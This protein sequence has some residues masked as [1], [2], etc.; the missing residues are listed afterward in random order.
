[1]TVA[2]EYTTAASDILDARRTIQILAATCRGIA[3]SC[4]QESLQDQKP[5]NNIPHPNERL[6]D[7]VVFAIIQG[8]IG[9]MCR[10]KIWPNDFDSDG[11]IKRDRIPRGPPVISWANG[12]PFFTVY[13]GYYILG[14]HYLA[15][16]S[17]LLSASSTSIYPGCLAGLVI[18]SPSAIPAD[19]MLLSEQIQAFRTESW[20][21]INWEPKSDLERTQK[22]FTTYTKDHS[23]LS[24]IFFGEDSFGFAPP[25]REAASYNLHLDPAETA[26]VSPTRVAINVWNQTRLERYVNNMNVQFHFPIQQ[27]TLFFDE[28]LGHPMS[29]AQ[30]TLESPLKNLT[31][32]SESPKKKHPLTPV[33]PVCSKTSEATTT[34]KRPSNDKLDEDTPSKKRRQLKTHS[35]KMKQQQ[36]TQQKQQHQQHHLEQEQKQRQ[37][38]Q[39][40]QQQQQEQK[41]QPPAGH[42]SRTA[43]QI[44][45]A[46]TTEFEIE[47]T[48]LAFDDLTKIYNEIIQDRETLDTSPARAVLRL[49][50]TQQEKHA[51]YRDL[52]ETVQKG[53][54]RKGRAVKLIFQER[55]AGVA[56][57]D[58]LTPS[59][60]PALAEGLAL[61]TPISTDGDVD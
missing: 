17:W 33:T 28:A 38:Q 46:F 4:A 9:G 47:E 11:H 35:W 44:G 19:A 52:L 26:T 42:S 36:Q 27:F 34:S 2:D 18:A 40:Q 12:I 23:R 48:C 25:I 5:Q 10:G 50:K 3:Q 61:H 54:G 41:R 43:K 29:K 60:T 58:D 57:P 56:F 8:R 30:S 14:G 53:I 22:N 15:R 24:L 1:M 37:K 49:Y 45:Q 20:K 16:R 6:S 51:R 32:E 21:K 7:Q 13:G 31:L 39:Q 55:L 59:P